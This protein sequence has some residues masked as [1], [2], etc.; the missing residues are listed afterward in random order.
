M[1]KNTR[2][3]LHI[4]LQYC[5]PER[6]SLGTR[7]DQFH[8]YTLQSDSTPGRVWNIMRFILVYM[9]V[10]ECSSVKYERNQ[11]NEYFIHKISGDIGV[12]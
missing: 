3:S 9:T 7:L 12:P 1:R 8:S 6:R 10:Q 4:Q 2:L 11:D 5:V